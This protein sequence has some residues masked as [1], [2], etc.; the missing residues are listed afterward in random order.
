M[1][2]LK[3]I[4]FKFAFKKPKAKKQKTNFAEDLVKEIQKESKP[5]FKK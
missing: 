3:D 5:I 1:K 2:K 4:K